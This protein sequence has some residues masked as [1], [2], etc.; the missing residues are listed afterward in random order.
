M[1]AETARPLPDRPEIETRA[2]FGTKSSSRCPHPPLRGQKELEV[3]RASEGD[4]LLAEPEPL[5]GRGG[6]HRIEI[7]G[8]VARTRAGSSS[9]SQRAAGAA[10]PS[11]DSRAR[12]RLS[13]PPATPSRRPSH[14]SPLRRALVCRK[15]Q[16]REIL[17]RTSRD[18][19]LAAA[20]ARLRTISRFCASMTASP[21]SPRPPSTCGADE[22]VDDD[23]S[24]F[25]E[26][27]KIP[28]SSRRAEAEERA[29]LDGGTAASR[30]AIRRY[31]R[32]DRRG[33]PPRRSAW[34]RT[35]S[36]A[37]GEGQPEQPAAAIRVGVQGL[38]SS[39]PAEAEYGRQ[40]GDRYE[41]PLPRPFRERQ[42]AVGRP[43]RHET[44][45][46]GLEIRDRGRDR[47]AAESRGA[48]GLR[49]DPVR[50]RRRAF[51]WSSSLRYMFSPISFQRASRAKGEG[52]LLEK[53]AIARRAPRRRRPRAPWPRRGRR[54]RRG[55]SARSRRS[56]ENRDCRAP[57]RKASSRE[58][59]SSR[60]VRAC[61][62]R[63]LGRSRA[64]PA[65]S[66]NWAPNM[67]EPSRPERTSRSS[68]SPSARAS[69]GSRIRRP[70]D[71]SPRPSARRGG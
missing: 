40:L 50:N 21:D 36:D 59:G 57:P 1:A 10:T 4:P 16:P 20:R 23:D 49:H 35:S 52:A 47:G 12:S 65:F 8:P 9:V 46:A 18:E 27:A 26:F 15:H 48:Q 66:R 37:P 25:G 58:G 24:R 6:E 13:R 42:E 63:P 5:P 33:W 38:A 28:S 60:A 17:G 54:G 34:T 39:G 70:R 56:R 41:H 11:S 7:G 64:R 45:E 44:L 29:R 67:P 19:G 22:Q 61:P 69:E 32:R 3:L 55:R 14:R 53:D 68:L 30:R 71:R 62:G 51:P 31:A 2:A 43:A